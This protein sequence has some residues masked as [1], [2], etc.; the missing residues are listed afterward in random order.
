MYACQLM[1]PCVDWA[2][3]SMKSSPRFGA[4]CGQGSGLRACGRRLQRGTAC[5]RRW[6]ARAGSGVRASGRR[7]SA[8]RCCT[9][10]GRAM[11]S[12]ELA[13]LFVCDTCTDLVNFV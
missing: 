5:A 8:V 7:A 2:L 10:V 11:A 12:A 9:H 4:V 6:A 13:K 1:V 3:K